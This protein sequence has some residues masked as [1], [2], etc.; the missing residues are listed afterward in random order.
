MSRI[1][2]FKTLL[3][4]IIAFISSIAIAQEHKVAFSFTGGI[5]DDGFAGF[6]T[7]DYKVN[8]YDY[9]QLNAQASFTNLELQE[10]E[11]PINLYAFQAGFFFD[12]LRNNS[13]TFAVGIGVGGLVGY[14][15][16]NGGDPEIQNNLRLD[17]ET[18]TLLYG[19]YAGIDADIFLSPTVAINIKANEA[20]HINS[21]V[22]E[23]TPYIGLGLKLIIK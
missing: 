4:L 22:G 13:R 7:V 15:I 2:F 5:V 20:Y 16:I 14:E 23:L 10:I 21:N 17:I 11:I 3:V 19:A 8:D 9:I 6:V 12:I 1:F 18:N